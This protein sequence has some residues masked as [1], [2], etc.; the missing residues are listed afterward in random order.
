M[1]WVYKH[2]IYKILAVCFGLYCHSVF[3]LTL[4]GEQVQ[5]G[6]LFAQV[7]EGSKVWFNEKPVMISKQGY[8][9]LGFG[10]D[11]KPGDVLSWQLPGQKRQQ[12]ILK[13]K[14]RRYNIQHIKGIKK[15]IMQPDPKALARARKEARQVRQARARRF[16]LENFHQGFILPLKGRIT[17]V[18]GSQRVYNGV[19]KRPHYGLD[20]A[21]KTGTLVSAP[22][23]GVVTLVHNDM[24]YS[25]GTLI[26]DH[27][28]GLSSSFLHLSEILVKPGQSVEQ[29]QLIGKVGSSGRSTG[30]HL[31]WRMNW[32]DRRIDPQL[33]IP[34]S[35]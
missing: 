23:G 8:L 26:I 34:A 11:S 2:W 29:G 16:A 31:D 14:A 20:I 35:R 32:L 15:S 6:L 21:A 18:F 7:P 30:S 27:G 28:H 12:K 17:G 5:G 19:P 10:R 24:F 1:H 13:P 3:A 25:G 22:A 9:V 4:Q 33:L